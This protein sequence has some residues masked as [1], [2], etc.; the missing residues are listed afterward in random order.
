[1]DNKQ[2]KVFPF[3]AFVCIMNQLLLNGN[4]MRMQFNKP[5]LC[6]TYKEAAFLHIGQDFFRQRVNDEL[7]I[8]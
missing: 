1:M 4:C 6:L 3:L 7:V 8:F 2:G 5:Q